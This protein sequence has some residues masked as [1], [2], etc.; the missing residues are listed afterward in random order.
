MKPRNRTW[1]PWL[2]LSLACSPAIVRW[3]NQL[4][5]DPPHRYVLLVLPLVALLLLHERRVPRALGAPSRSGRL[6][7]WASLALGF[8]AQ[9]VGAASASA[10]VANVGLPLS[11]LGV[12]LIV[13]RPRPEILLLTFGL[14]PIPGFVLVL[15]SPGVESWLGER[16]A[17]LLGALGWTVGG[18]GP[19]LLDRGRRFE[20]F[21]VDAGIVTALCAAEYGW[22]RAARAG[23]SL[24]MIIKQAGLS[25]LAGGLVQ[26]LLLVLC[27]LSLPLGFPDAGRFLLSFGPAIAF[28]LA[29]ALDPLRERRP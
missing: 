8:V 28:G 6:A 25:G 22:Y 3:A 13:G 18:G 21:S 17:T 27:A 16:L 2:G 1:L 26:P 24:A 5:L 7:G 10:F 12:G 11:I 20:L 4:L 19:L 15:G 14:V 29:A 23:R 9:L